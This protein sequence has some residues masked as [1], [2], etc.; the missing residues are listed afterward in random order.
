VNPPD[1]HADLI[2]KAAL[3]LTDR[4]AREAYISAAC[5]DDLALEARVRRLIE[6]HEHG[7]IV[8]E[9]SASV[10]PEMKAEMARLKPEEA[11]ER[12]GRY[13]LLE[14]IGEGGFGVVWVAEQMEPVRRRVALK[15]IKLGMDTKEFIA[16]F[17]QERQA[18]A[19]MEHPN[20][21]RVFDAGAT[22]HGR[23]FF[24]MELV[25]GVKITEYCDQQELPMKE[26]LGLFVQVCQAV[27]HAHQKGII[28][29][30]L[31]PSNIL[32]TINDGAPVP[33]VIDFGVAKATQ[34]RLTEHTVYTQFQ[35]MVGTP[36]YMSPEQA[37]MTSLDIDTRSDIY[38]LGVLLYELL[39]GCTPIEEET[40]ARVG[41]DEIRRVIREVDAL[42]PSTR[43][44]SLP[45]GELT[46]TAK[47][48]QIEAAKLPSALRGDLD[49][50]VMKAIEKDRT[51]RYE[52]ANG[53]ALDLERY[54]DGEPVLARPPSKLYRFQKTVRRNKLAFAASGVVLLTLLVALGV[55]TASF[56]RERKAHEAASLSATTAQREAYKLEQMA[57]F[58]QDM[59]ARV[60]TQF[61]NG[62]DLD[63]LKEIVNQTL[64][65][66]APELKDQPVIEAE[67][68][69]ALG[70]IFFN[71][72]DYAAAE[73]MEREALRLRESVGETESKG[74]DMLLT[75]LSNVLMERGEL[76]QAAE[77]LRRT[78]EIEKKLFG[79]VSAEY[80]NP[81]V[82]LGLVC[83]MRSDLAEAERLTRAGLQLKRSLPGDK[84]DLAVAINNLGLVLW[85]QGRFGEAEPLLLEA[86]NLSKALLLEN[87]PDVAYS[88]NNLALV[89]R[90]RGELDEAEKLF[91]KAISLLPEGHP[92]ATRTRSNLSGVVRRRAA[93]SND[94]AL[95]NESLQLNPP[96]ALTVDAL[97]AAYAGDA[98]TPLASPSDAA[99]GWRFTNTASAANW[100]A[101]DFSDAAWSPA[102]AVAGRP[103]FIPFSP[104][105]DRSVLFHKDVWLR[106]EF[107]LAN[108]PTGKIF[109]R[110][111]RCH[112]AEVFVNGIRVAPA[113]DWTDAAVIVPCSE[114]GQRAFRIGPNIVAVH[115]RD[116]DG[117]TN[118]DVGFYVTNE[119]N[120][121][122]NQLLEQ[123]NRM[124]QAEPQRAELY[125]ARASI[126]ARLGRLDEATA[127]LNEAIIRAPQQLAWWFQLAA[128]LLETGKLPGYARHRLDALARFP[129]PG[130]PTIAAQLAML[131]LLQPLGSPELES[132]GKFGDRAGHAQWGDKG[133]VQRQLAKGLSEYR[134]GR[135]ASAIE[136]SGRTVASAARLDLT[137][138]THERSRN[139]AAAAYA[140]QA[141]AY[142]RENQS[143]EAQEALAKAIDLLRFQCPQLDSAD[144]G[145]EWPELLIAQ[146]LRREAEALLAGKSGK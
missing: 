68:R 47:R 119:A 114:E 17:E 21:A 39:T 62:R 139:R 141:M 82:D 29:R 50:I 125:S 100:A 95:F 93:L 2:I 38:S 126:F 135:F 77:V 25:R 88:S 110:L 40:L 9:R 120:P 64:T 54:L 134:Q 30:D 19:M 75:Q 79:E 8:M 44:R 18:L 121:G 78:L 71:L 92:L 73:A 33:K 80:G 6:A 67:L 72:G 43:V 86:H 81:L 90:D 118:I 45:G 76:D 58:L 117:G 146:I 10:S 74:I 34:G 53:L 103:T 59:F 96:D 37:E 123:F 113:V 101:P 98:L 28:H 15:I 11:G 65:R 57:R 42:R 108:A 94:R 4:V 99:P 105:I 20:I 41:L 140:I 60:S 138:W 112:D 83:W 144:L 106:R 145:R 55:S 5:Q 1:G 23:P 46:S 142:H 97:A 27:Q 109:L 61:A 31:K 49:W 12:I 84:K 22:Q 130:S 32:V 122:R 115:C 104:R 3:E 102:P 36:R 136:W 89:F 111:N 70:G 13:R 16:R 14:Q 69:G 48:R 116:A 132:A 35:Q 137:G 7:D 26:R 87:H 127:D 51:R 66:F 107:N 129:D 85:E 128:V 124:I 133:L 56:V 91:R 63:K 52:T 131:L 24:V 143:R